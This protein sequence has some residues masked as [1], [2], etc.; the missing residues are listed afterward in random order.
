MVKIA[1]M[2]LRVSCINPEQQYI[3]S[4]RLNGEQHGHLIPT[5]S[6]DKDISCLAVRQRLDEGLRSKRQDDA[7]YV[8]TRIV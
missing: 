2:H 6:M 8:T 5:Q 7:R 4:C 1:M 3:F